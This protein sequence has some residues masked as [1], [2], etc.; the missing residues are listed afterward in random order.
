[1]M[2]IDDIGFPANHRDDSEELPRTFVKPRKADCS[3]KMWRV[4]RA[5]IVSFAASITVSREREH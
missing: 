3:E 2:S 4:G 5:S 1:M